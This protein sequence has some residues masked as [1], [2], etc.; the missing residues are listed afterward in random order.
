MTVSTDTSSACISELQNSS[1]FG[2][3]ADR[4][5]NIISNRQR[6][7]AKI[8]AG[9]KHIARIIRNER[10]LAQTG[11]MQSADGNAVAADLHIRTGNLVV[12]H[13]CVVYEQITRLDDDFFYRES[14]IP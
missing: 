2:S 9:R 10:V 11:H 14:G 1:A 5:R 13:A 3:P 4:V 7:S 8:L 6:R 12:H